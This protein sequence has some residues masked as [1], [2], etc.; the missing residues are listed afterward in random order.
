M[1]TYVLGMNLK[2]SVQLLKL[3]KNNYTASFVG[4]LTGWQTSLGTKK[5]FPPLMSCQKIHQ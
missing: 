4:V 2:L 3:D 5:Y 1:I